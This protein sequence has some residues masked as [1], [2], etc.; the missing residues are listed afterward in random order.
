MTEAASSP[1][2]SDE[3]TPLTHEDIDAILKF[4]P[5]FEK[6]DFS[7]GI[8]REGKGEFSWVEYC[9]DVLAFELAL[10]EHHFIVELD[11]EFWQRHAEEYYRNPD[12]L[13][14]ADIPTLRRILTVHVRKDRLCEGHLARMFTSGQIT[15]ILH[16]LRD[17]AE[18]TI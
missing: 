12:L 15:G 18:E 11:W 8:A 6:P 10:Y 4:L 3:S 2:L 7:P 9:H 5:K 17:I 1:G 13:A 16:R 14:T